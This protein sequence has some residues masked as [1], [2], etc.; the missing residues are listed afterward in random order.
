MTLLNWNGTRETWWSLLFKMSSEILQIWSDV[1][2]DVLK[3][4]PPEKPYLALYDLSQ[5][6]AIGYLNLVQKRMLNLGITKAGE[7]QALDIIAQREGLTR[8][9]GP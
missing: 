2:L 3:N 4:W 6:G 7:E 9:G 5:G 1:A 8:A